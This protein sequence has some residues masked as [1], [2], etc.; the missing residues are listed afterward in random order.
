MAAMR[1]P[2]HSQPLAV[3]LMLCLFLAQLGV[4]VHGVIHPLESLGATQPDKQKTLPHSAACEHFTSQA[5]G[6][7]LPA[8][9]L[10]FADAPELFFIRPPQ[11]LP[12]SRSSPRYYQSRAPPLSA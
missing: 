5:L 1:R 8:T 11:Q 6:S 4:A 12:E 9:A 2:L 3:M 10:A 7:A